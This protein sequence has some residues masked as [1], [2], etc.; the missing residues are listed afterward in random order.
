MLPSALMVSMLA[1]L[2]LSF[3]GWLIPIIASI[4]SKRSKALTL[5]LIFPPTSP[6]ASF[7][8]LVKDWKSGMAPMVCYVLTLVVLTLGAAIAESTEKSRLMAYE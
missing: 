2:L 1:G 5:F 4:R 6:F 8:L 7:V 3:L